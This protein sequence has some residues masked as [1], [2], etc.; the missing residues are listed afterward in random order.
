M[1]CS[2]CNTDNDNNFRFCTKCGGPLYASGQ[3]PPNTP[4]T[5][6]MNQNG[7]IVPIGSG[8][9]ARRGGFS[10]QM[11]PVFI[12]AGVVI[13]LLLIAILL[14]FFVFRSNV[15]DIDTYRY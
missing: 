1:V 14:V 11:M 13:F 2:N 10:P 12:I 8:N 5:Q 9:R 6:N 15:V 7:P 4:N 3:V